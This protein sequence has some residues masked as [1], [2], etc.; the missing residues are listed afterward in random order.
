MLRKTDNECH[1]ALDWAADYGCVNT[2]ELLIRKGLSPLRLDRANRSPLH[3]AVAKR[4]VAAAR[5]L[6]SCGCDPHACD[7][8]GVSAMSLAHSSGFHDIVGALSVRTGRGG[9]HKAH[10]GAHLTLYSPSTSGSPRSHAIYRRNYPR[11]RYVVAHLLVFL[12]LWMLTIAIPSILWI[13][14]VGGSGLAYRSWHSKIG[15]MEE[16]DDSGHGEPGLWQVISVD[17]LH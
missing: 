4:R 15:A 9:D 8:E 13:C 2:L 6:V 17:K 5:F 14:I 1:N 16:E 10:A 11:I 3:F 7:A 12:L